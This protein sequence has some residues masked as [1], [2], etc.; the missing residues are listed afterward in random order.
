MSGAT[1]PR[2]DTHPGVIVFED[3]LEQ[4]TWTRHAHEVPPAVAWVEVGEDRWVP[5]V[6]V[7]MNGDGER[8]TILKLDA[9]GRVLE[10]TTGVV[11]GR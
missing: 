3:K 8:R 9:D 2:G 11:S 10:T 4:R 6:R 7:E 1:S 5:V